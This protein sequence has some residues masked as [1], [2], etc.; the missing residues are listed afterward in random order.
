MT[1]RA[2]PLLFSLGMMPFL[3]APLWAEEKA[4]E[5]TPPVKP[6]V[7]PSPRE[8]RPAVQ[9]GLA[10]L[11]KDGLAWMNERKCI[12]C[13]HGPF[14]LWS[15]NEAR[16]RGFTVDPKKLTDWTT[17][18]LNLYLTKEKENQTKRNGC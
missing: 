7:L 2:L 18:A 14:L 5:T 12:A 10:Y 1:R 15:H 4:R 11:E 6:A 9:R 16:L 17:Q 3:A 13:H 8:V